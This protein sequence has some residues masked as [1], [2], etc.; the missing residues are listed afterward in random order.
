[1]PDSMPTTIKTGLE[2]FLKHL[3]IE[4]NYSDL[5]I[6][7]YRRDINDFL[8]F[9]EKADKTVD[10]FANI[11]HN[12]IRAYL[13]KMKNSGLSVATVSRRLSSLRSFFKF[14][15]RVDMLTDNPLSGIRT[16]R[17]G[18]PLPHYLN[19][20]D[21][22]RLLEAPD[23]RNLSGKRDKA[24]LEV[25]YSTGMRVGELTS[26]CFA[27]IDFNQEVI[28][29][30]GK[31]K[32]ER[33]VALG[34]FA[35][36]AL[37]GYIDA[38]NTHM[39]GAATDKVFLNRLGTPLTSR[40]VRRMLDKYLKITGLNSKLSPH[41]IRHSFATHLLNAGADLRSVQELLGHK[42]LSTTQIYTHVSTEHL[43]LIYEKA[44]PHA[45]KLT[46]K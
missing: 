7:A 9:S 36:S 44:H 1:M 2:L 11:G 18:R 13:G 43:K 4:R 26:L 27:D 12:D 45:E 28:R 10:D 3:N 33:L 30:L 25:L 21:I 16:P 17:R 15:I 8:D 14:L 40:S 34:R 5:T 6:K 19:T 42:N 41:S 32:K 38:R 23:V 29:V 35:A 31:G 24:I 37:K 39:A 20:R 22:G 46:D